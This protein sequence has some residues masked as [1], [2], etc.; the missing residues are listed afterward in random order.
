MFKIKLQNRCYLIILIIDDGSIDTKNY[1]KKSKILDYFTS[2]N[3]RYHDQAVAAV[4]N[5]DIL[6]VGEINESNNLQVVI[7]QC[8]NCIIKWYTSPYIFFFKI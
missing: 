6:N 5:N 2:K 3:E 8:N 4:V 1:K 7:F